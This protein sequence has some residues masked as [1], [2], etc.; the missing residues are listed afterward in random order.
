MRNTTE[1]SGFSA[2]IA[3]P[4][5][6]ERRGVA[7]ASLIASAGLAIATIVAATVVSAGIA[8]AS[9]VGNIIDNEG[10]LFALALLLGLLFIGMG[11]LTILT[12]PG[13]K[14]KPR[15]THDTTPHHPTVA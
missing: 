8:R 3:H 13:D 6:Q 4:L 7:L 10:S 14:P 11:G 2:P 5:G 9:A 1:G 12:M 15:K